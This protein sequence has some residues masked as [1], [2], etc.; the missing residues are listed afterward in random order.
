MEINR[1]QFIES[2]A[3]AG[4]VA[5][6]GTQ[7]SAKEKPVQEHPNLLFV[8]CDQMR[9]QAM[10]FLGKEPVITP[11]LDKFSTQALTLTHAASNYP[12]CSPYRAMLMTGKWP[13]ANKVWSNCT[14]NTEPH[15]CE[16]Q[17]DDR[18]W[19]DVLKDKGY[20]LGY[21]G[22]W[23]L[24]S[25]RAPYID[26]A[27]NRGGVKWN[28]WCPPKRRH[29]FD[30]WHSYG[31]YDHHMKPMYWSTDAK[32]DDFHYVDQW[33]PEYEADLAI[34][35]LKNEEGEYRKRGEPFALTVSMNPP[36]MPYKAHPPE[37][38]DPYEDMPDEEIINKPSIPA[39]D[40][41]WGKYY[42]SNIRHYYAM[43]SGVDKQFG[44]ILKALDGLG[45]SEN[46][47]VVFTSDHGDCLGTHDWVSKNVAYEESMRVPFMIRYPGT[48]ESKQDDLLMSAPDIYPTLLDLMG[49]KDDIPQEVEGDSH[50]EALSTGK[51][52]RPTSQIYIWSPVGKPQI[53]RRGVRTHRYTMVIETF[54]DKPTTK[55]LYDNQEDPYQLKNIAADQP[56]TVEKLFREEL[57]PWLK[58]TRDPW[59]IG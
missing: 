41:K 23:H 3:A 5:A 55:T 43:I 19:S 37:Y 57:R 9:G 53:G 47:I 14:S 36:H 45:L 12:V 24:D 7:I 48:I 1:R 50:A 33:G 34:K 4:S 15:G 20:S 40:T 28:D 11:A 27:N 26:C 52:S 58:R 13:N 25:P 8:F 39:A 44:R 49:F 38:L 2:A 18:C 6:I 32:R 21:I 10:G 17:E 30:F 46:T 35:Y 42:R 29:G 16:L 56:E 59:V 22:K 31:T 51:G 54:E